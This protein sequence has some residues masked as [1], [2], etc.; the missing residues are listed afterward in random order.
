MLSAARVRNASSLVSVRVNRP[1]AAAVLLPKPIGMP[2]PFASHSVWTRTY[3]PTFKHVSVPGT[4]QKPAPYREQTFTYSTGLAFT[5]RSAACAPE[6]A[7][8]PAAETRRRLFTIFIVVPPCLLR[9]EGSVFGGSDCAHLEGPLISPRPPGNPK[10]NSGVQT[11]R[12][13]EAPSVA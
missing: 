1:A 11:E 9:W 7:T 5:G 8:R 12:L 2:P 10:T 3:E 6:T 4:Y 13:G